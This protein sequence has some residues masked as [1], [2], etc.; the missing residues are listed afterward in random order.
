MPIKYLDLPFGVGAHHM[1]TALSAPPQKAFAMA[2]ANGVI[3]NKYVHVLSEAAGSPGELIG[4]PGDAIG[5]PST[6]CW[7]RNE[8]RVIITK[9]HLSQSQ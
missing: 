1:P 8:S 4:T 9:A 7:P 6:L 2:V 5:N 3:G